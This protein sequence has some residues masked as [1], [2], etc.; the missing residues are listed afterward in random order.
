MKRRIKKIGGSL[1]RRVL[2]LGGF[3][4]LKVILMYHRVC[5]AMPAELHDPAMF[6][7]AQ[8]LDMHIRELKRYFDIVPVDRL[9]MSRFDR[10]RLCAITFD[11]GWLDNYTVAWPV[12]KKHGVPATVFIPLESMKARSKYWFETLWDIAN[13]AANKGKKEELLNYFGAHG[14]MRIL[15]EPIQES[16]CS[17]ISALKDVPPQKLDGIID[18][19]CAHFG[20]EPRQDDYLLTERHMREMS[21]DGITF[22]A[23]GLSHAILTRLS[24]EEKRREIFGSREALMA[25]GYACSDIFSYPNGDW[26]EG[27]VDLVREAG[28]QGAVTTQLGPVNAASRSFQLHRVALHDEISNTPSL[29]WF[30]LYQAAARFAV[31]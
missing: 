12:L 23:H 6:A 27:S 21:A 10:T 15:R 24:Y 8:T 20:V 3:P 28:Y 22:G 25:S 17:V 16:M 30:R 4:K 31:N 1:F 26:D 2:A 5:D 13:A 29:F 14:G 9:V 18:K 19:A 11:D 7:T